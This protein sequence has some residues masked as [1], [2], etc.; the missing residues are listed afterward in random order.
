MFILCRLSSPKL[1]CVK[2]GDS[3]DLT[4]CHTCPR[5]V[6]P[7]PLLAL[8]RGE[9]CLNRLLLVLVGAT[10]HIRRLRFRSV[11]W[12]PPD[13]FAQHV[14]VLSCG[15]DSRSS[16]ACGTKKLWQA[17]ALCGKGETCLRLATTA[18]TTLTSCSTSALR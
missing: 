17:S 14:F 12:I 4:A 8:C 13:T 11:S 18:M 1:R 15:C 10:T 7:S 16:P 9:L 2:G 6:A 5:N 3:F